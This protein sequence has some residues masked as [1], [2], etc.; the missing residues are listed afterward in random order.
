[1]YGGQLTFLYTLGWAVIG[2]L[3]QMALLWLLYRL[4]VNTL[5]ISSPG[6]K[7]TLAA[8]LLFT[9]FLWFI[10]TIF[11]FY[12]GVTP[13]LVAENQ[14]FNDNNEVPSA[15]KPVLSYTSILYLVL[16]LVPLYQFIRNYR[17]A[18]AL[19]RTGTQKTAIEWRLFADKISSQ[20]NIKRKVSVFLSEFIQSPVTIG[21]LKPVIL[22]P[23]AVLSNLSVAQAEALI[24]HELAHIRRNDYIL[25]IFIQLIRSV[26]YFNPF[27]KAFV[28][29]I[30]TEREK[31]CDNMVLQYQYS[32]TGYATALLHLQQVKQPV[33]FM[34]ASGNKDS[35]TSR[36][37]HILGISPKQ[38]IPGGTTIFSLLLCGLFVFSGILMKPAKGDEKNVNIVKT[39]DKSI[40]PVPAYAIVEQPAAKTEQ[41]FFTAN[42]FSTSVNKKSKPAVEKKDSSPVDNKQN[43]TADNNFRLVS[44]SEATLPALEVVQE[45]EIKE[46]VATSK[47]IAEEMQWK[48][49][50]KSLADVFTA[51]EKNELRTLYNES[52]NK[53][54][55]SPLEDKLKTIYDK[56]DWQTVNARLS[57]AMKKV[58]T[59]SLLSVYKNV[60]SKLDALQLLL[61]NSNSTGIPDTDITKQSL[62][63]KKE[64]VLHLFTT[65][66]AISN[67]KKIVEL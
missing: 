1:M 52:V 25:N 34:A 12:P 42:S 45:M 63:E 64:R 58:Q 37:N 9:G 51:D 21:F 60:I 59:D 2:S 46:A 17:Y 27:V 31:S 29:E 8:V 15:L 40:F 49:I 33:F 10:S 32:A 43:L 56:I 24:L 26:L 18:E 20:L 30:E 4:L 44:Y 67:G 19:R 35:L 3:W 11:L 14:L 13:N 53:A 47:R 5:S 48:N 55:W 66:K 50:E 7:A 6:K 16:L 28:K 38:N 39:S 57:N 65:L 22:M 62:V 61:K 36:I 54:D 23:V 41:I